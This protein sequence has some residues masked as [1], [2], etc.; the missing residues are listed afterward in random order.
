MNGGRSVKVLGLCLVLI[1]SVILVLS[2]FSLYQSANGLVG[3]SPEAYKA[4][5]LIGEL[6]ERLR[7]ASSGSEAKIIL[8]TLD[9]LPKKLISSANIKAVEDAYNL[10]SVPQENSADTIIS[11]RIDLFSELF[12]FYR[13]LVVQ[14][15]FSAASVISKL[16]RQGYKNV[17]D[18]AK[19]Q[20]ILAFTKLTKERLDQISEMRFSASNRTGV[21]GWLKNLNEINS[22]L[23]D[24][25]KAQQRWKIDGEKAFTKVES[26]FTKM[27]NEI[28]ARSQDDS[29]GLQQ[30][31]LL[32]TFFFLLA[33][34]A[35]FAVIYMI[36]RSTD[37]WFTKRLGAALSLVSKY[38]LNEDKGKDVEFLKAD[39]KWRPFLERVLVY[40]KTFLDGINSEV[41]IT[42]SIQTPIFLLSASYQ[43]IHWNSEIMKLLGTRSVMEI[44]KTSF[45]DFF[46]NVEFRDIEGISEIDIEEMEAKFLSGHKIRFQISATIAGIRI[47]L[48]FRGDPIR[49]GVY[50]GGFVMSIT[51]LREEDS[52]VSERVSQSLEVINFLVSS[53]E[54]HQNVDFSSFDLTKVPDKVLPMV[55]SL[56]A[57]QLE[58]NEQQVLWQTEAEATL[59]KVNRQREI[60]EN[61]KRDIA[62]LKSKVVD[63]DKLIQERSDLLEETENNLT[64]LQKRL[65]SSD[66][67]WRRTIASINKTKNL[68]DEAIQYERTVQAIRAEML[69]WYSKF[70]ASTDS[71]RR[72]RDWVKLQSVNVNIGSEEIGI[73]RDRARKFS[74]A[75]A[76]F[77]EKIVA[78][79]KELQSF[80]ERHPGGAVLSGMKPVENWD[81]LVSEI[82]KFYAEL[83]SGLDQLT[84]EQINTIKDFEQ[85]SQI[86]AEVGRVQEDLNMLYTNS[87]A[88]NQHTMEALDRWVKSDLS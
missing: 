32:L 52:R 61:N 54:H 18:N 9:S 40:E 30:R 70:D 11:A 17:S 28:A 3:S 5:S 45:R 10:D 64:Q 27:N 71:V 65:A 36:S 77:Y 73:F 25:A 16:I 60:L 72:C 76:D 35:S 6:R 19:P 38:G 79:K 81:E 87:A 53:L 80:V 21:N 59:E 48:E 44:G 43:V 51:D 78:I 41:A 68:E 67:V 46:K 85:L 39:K 69:T 47:P 88:I 12:N 66:A 8:R 57:I 22:R 37:R 42:R 26:I 63:M 2:L 20:S 1:F 15:D 56:K 31:F 50:T 62:R 75:I 13:Q 84:K 29:V 23:D 86:Q 74:Y 34:L 83:D 4:S 58:R 49:S 55:D 24:A 7:N 33:L 82:S 14:R